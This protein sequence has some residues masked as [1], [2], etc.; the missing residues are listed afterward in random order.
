MNILRKLNSRIPLQSR[1]V[2]SLIP[3]R[4]GS[5]GVINK[6]LRSSNGKPLIDYTISVALKFQYVD[7]FYVSTDRKLILEYAVIPQCYC[8]K[9]P[10]QFSQ[11]EST[12]NGVVA[13]FIST[14][15][16]ET[17]NIDPLLLYLRSTLPF[18]NGRR[19]R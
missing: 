12:A 2:F 8:I 13:H 1:K 18:R 6:N 19:H 16:A 4:A 14:L 10:S 7:E 17:K 5:K 11:D 15:G 9:R 3:T